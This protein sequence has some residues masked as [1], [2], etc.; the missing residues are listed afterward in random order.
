MTKMIIDLESHPF[1]I[2]ARGGIPVG[3]LMIF[4]VRPQDNVTKSETPVVRV[5]KERN[6]GNNGND[7][8]LHHPFRYNETPEQRAKRELGFPIEGVEP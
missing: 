5:L 1:G 6:T 2:A 3:Q 7:F 4:A 8:V